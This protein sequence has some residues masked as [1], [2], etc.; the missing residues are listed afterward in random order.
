MNEKHLSPHHGANSIPTYSVNMVHSVESCP[1]FNT[2]VGRRFKAFFGR[3]EEAAAKHGIKIL[4]A[5]A[6]VLEHLIFY[7]VEAPSEQAAEDYFKE[8]G[9]AFWNSIA[10]RQVTAVEDVVK[11]VEP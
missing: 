2:Q 9:F 6:S 10:I 3:R 1:L 8:T 11:S 5:W 4:S 7:I